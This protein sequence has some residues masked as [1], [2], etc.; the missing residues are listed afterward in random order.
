MRAERREQ[1]AC[2]ALRT[3]VRDLHLYRF[4]AAPTLA[5]ETDLVLRLKAKPGD[6]WE[7]RFDPPL[8]EQ[9]TSQIEDVQ[10]GRNVFRQGRIYCFRCDSSECAHSV[11]PS[12]LTVFDGYE[13]NGLPEWRELAQV[14]I[15]AK[16]SRVDQLFEKSPG[17]V[18]VL[19]L[20][21]D[22]RTRQLSSFGRSSKTYA[23]L[24]QV[25]AGYFLLPARGGGAAERLAVTFQAVEARGDKGARLHLNA[26]AGIPGGEPLADMLASGWQDGLHRARETAAS[27]V[28]RIELLVNAARE[29]GD[30]EG[31]RQAMRQIPGVMRRLAESVERTG[32]QGA[33]RTRHVEQ[34]RH[35]QRPVHKA[36]EDLMSAAFESFF[37]DEKTE[38]TVV[39]GS[40]GRAHVFSG[41]GRHV[42]SFLLRPGSVDFRVRTQRW[43]AIPAAEAEA[44]RRKVERFLP[45][46]G[47]RAPT[48]GT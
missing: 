41:D 29:R 18:T 8:A 14:L 6:T 43:R 1:A 7:L 30:A 4:G 47:E 40:Q 15:A 3:F 10:A 39:C 35:E 36:L 12:P 13:P 37:F 5:E 42:T 21:H 16:D 46:K 9:L 11:P 20:G 19:R 48:P 24:G 25:V 23:V 32:R 22:L 34:R 45:G 26:I 38:T 44:F 31:V 28:E 2:D 27:A 17:V 33:R